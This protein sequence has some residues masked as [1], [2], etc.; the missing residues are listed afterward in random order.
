M[1]RDD[2]TEAARTAADFGHDRENPTANFTLYRS[3]FGMLYTDGVKHLLQESA[4]VV[5]PSGQGS[6]LALW[7]I[8][9]ITLAQPK[10]RI[11][12]NGFQLW[13]LTVDN[14]GAGPGATLACR[15]DSD[16]KPV[17]TERI[18]YTDFPLPSVKL[19]V[20]DGVI[21]LPNEY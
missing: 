4:G 14:H 5:G 2:T 19:Y 9:L 7:L 21:L 15:A 8:D 17:F 20:I 10:T 18:E 1:Q 11:A 12:C 6:T 3:A 16:Q 13:T